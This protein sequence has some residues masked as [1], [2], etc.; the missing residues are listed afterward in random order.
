MRADPRDGIRG[1]QRAPVGCA[2]SQVHHSHRG[3]PLERREC[4]C[5]EQVARE[6]K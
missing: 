4:R 6:R 1:P 5:V 2:F 3:R